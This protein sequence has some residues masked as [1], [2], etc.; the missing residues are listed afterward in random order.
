[1]KIRLTA[2][3]Q[4]AISVLMHRTSVSLDKQ[5]R[6]HLRRLAKTSGCSQAAI[7]REVLAAYLSMR[8]HRHA[9]RCI[10]MGASWS[11]S[12]SER[13]ETLLVGFGEQRKTH[14]GLRA[15]RGRLHWDGE[16]VSG[17]RNRV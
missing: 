15:L 14:A 7:I 9:P 12:L 13:A 11:R 8:G 5:T 4:R 2:K 16:V 3:T 17:R 10:G 1:V 6:E